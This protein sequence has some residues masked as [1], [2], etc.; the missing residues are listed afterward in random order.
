MVC[1]F[2]TRQARKK[3]KRKI[4]KRRRGN[5]FTADKEPELVE[6]QTQVGRG[7]IVFL[8]KSVLEEEP[9]ALVDG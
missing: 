6:G 7:S 3:S 2:G 4:A 1:F 9:V 8:F 5:I